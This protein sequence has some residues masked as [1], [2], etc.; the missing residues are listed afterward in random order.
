MS[1][2]YLRS[3]RPSSCSYSVLH[4]CRWP[5]TAEAGQQ[6]ERGPHFLP[7]YL[8]SSRLDGHVLIKSWDLSSMFTCASKRA[9]HAPNLKHGRVRRRARQRTGE[10]LPHTAYGCRRC[11]MRGSIGTAMG[12]LPPPAR[13]CRSEHGL[14][15]RPAAPEPGGGKALT[16]ADVLVDEP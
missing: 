6:T 3:G 10:P 15:T 5:Q 1:N 12:L 2:R 8:A 9:Q 13:R 14:G 11:P 4:W 16:R 7:G